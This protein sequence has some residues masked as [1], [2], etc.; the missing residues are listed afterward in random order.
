V[1]GNV[2]VA[3]EVPVDGGGAPYVT[4]VTAVELNETVVVATIVV[5]TAGA[6]ATRPMLASS[7]KRMLKML[8]IARAIDS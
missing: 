1:A 7:A 4:G 2:G 5:T 3:G 8:I 6:A